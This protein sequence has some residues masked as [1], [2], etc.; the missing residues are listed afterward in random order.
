MTP[1]W[2]CLMISAEGCPLGTFPDVRVEGLNSD[3]IR[4]STTR[5]PAKFRSHLKEIQSKA[6]D[7]NSSIGLEFI[8][9]LK[10]FMFLQKENPRQQ[11]CF[12]NK[13]KT[14]LWEKKNSACLGLLILE[15]QAAETTLTATPGSKRREVGIVTSWGKGSFPAVLTRFY[16]LYIQ[17]VVG[18]GISKPS[19][20]WLRI[21]YQSWVIIFMSSICRCF[22]FKDNSTIPILYHISIHVNTT[23]LSRSGSWNS[24]SPLAWP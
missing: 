15:E 10:V 1:Q 12:F 23:F 11:K 19:T 9:N 3:T 16:I 5:I 17:P 18:N 2:H 8:I 4:W 13:E 21:S 22:V 7:I 6:Y 20:V 24:H 14:D